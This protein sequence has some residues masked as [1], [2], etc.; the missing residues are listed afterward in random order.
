MIELHFDARE[1]E[2][3]MQRLE[4]VPQAV[5]RALYP[6]VSQVVD[7]ARDT[8]RTQLDAD[9]PLPATLLRQSITSGPVRATNQGVAGVVR[10]CSRPVRLI[11]YDVT[12]QTVTARKGLPSRR[13]PGFSYALRNN[14]R[15]MSAELPTESLPFIAIMHNRGK[16]GHSGVFQRTRQGKIKELY[17]PHVQYHATRPEVEAAVIASAEKDFSRIFPRIVERVLAEHIL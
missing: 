15:R 4:R 1:I 7:M 13:W 9:V 17:G 8:L 5:S 11:D 12:P 6:A 2:R 3:Q 16:G 10:V 14:A